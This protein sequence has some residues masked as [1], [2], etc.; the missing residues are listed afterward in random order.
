LVLLG[1][2]LIRSWREGGL[3]ERL[4]PV[5]GSFLALVVGFTLHEWGHAQAAYRLGGWRALP[6]LDRL[7]L[8]PRVHIEPMGLIA[9]LLL[10]LY[11]ARP[12]PVNVS[13]FYPTER[14]SMMLVA[15][16]GPLMNLGLGVAGALVLRWL[17]VLDLIGPGELSQGTLAYFG[18]SVLVQFSFINL[19][20]FFFNLLPFHPLDGWKVLFGLLPNEQSIVL[21]RYE[22]L[23]YTLLVFMLVLSFLRLPSPIGVIVY[24]LSSAIFQIVTGFAY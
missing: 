11:W 4:A 9:G 3:T 13:A 17:A 8:D 2:S 19:A 12:V 24:P 16:A 23:S 6:D 7:K 1:F 18:L 14:R 5:V 15:L 20:L 22:Q 21:A 10:G